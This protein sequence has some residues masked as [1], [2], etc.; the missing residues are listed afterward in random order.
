MAVGFS[1]YEIARSGLKVSERGLFVTG[2]N[3][4]NVNTPG[5]TRQQ[6]IIETNPYITEYGKNGK[7][8]QYGMGADI[9]ETR[10]IRHTFLD[11]VYRQ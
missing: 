2:H 5:F 10:Q 4:S 1:S 6:A 8:F 7:L 3:L 11:I 9:Q